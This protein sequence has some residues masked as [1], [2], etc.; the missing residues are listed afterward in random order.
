MALKAYL[1]NFA[2]KVLPQRGLYLTDIVFH[3]LPDFTWKITKGVSDNHYL[4]GTNMMEIKNSLINVSRK[5]K[6]RLIPMSPM[7]FTDYL[8]AGSH[9]WNKN[10]KG[11]DTRD[12]HIPLRFYQRR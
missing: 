9:K 8:K 5:A 7:L 6:W 2:N 1:L 4:N 11:L 10:D 3:R 12:L